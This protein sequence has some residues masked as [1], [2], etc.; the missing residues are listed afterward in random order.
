M[1]EKNKKQNHTLLSSFSRTQPVS[2][3]VLGCFVLLHIPGLGGNIGQVQTL[4]GILKNLCVSVMGKREKVGR[5]SAL[6]C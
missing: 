2:P 3:S 4:V 5:G 6:C 1:S